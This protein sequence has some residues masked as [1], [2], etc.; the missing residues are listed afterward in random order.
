MRLRRVCVY[1]C[2]DAVQ[3]LAEQDVASSAPHLVK[4]HAWM[5]ETLDL[6][7]AQRLGPGINT[8]ANESQQIRQRNTVHAASQSVEGELVCRIGPVLV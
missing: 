8:W 4:Y 1:F 2:H 7:A 5:K 3:A 6:A